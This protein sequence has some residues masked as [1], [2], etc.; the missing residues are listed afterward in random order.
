MW[1][2]VN[3]CLQITNFEILGGLCY[4]FFPDLDA[5]EIDELNEEIRK[6][7]ATIEKERKAA[8]EQFTKIE[9]YYLEKLKK[10]RGEVCIGVS[11]EKENR[12]LKEQLEKN[13]RAKI[14]YE[15]YQEKRVAGLKSEMKKLQEQLSTT[16]EYVVCCVAFRG[17]LFL[18]LFFC[19]NFIS[20][21]Y[22][23]DKM[24]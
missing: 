10:Q 21:I 23:L 1:V 14:S 11:L 22:L 19:P 6:L 24:F 8:Q 5:E 4:H 15:E 9:K 18:L 20:M 13:E 3:L 2:H 7:N 12:K 17:Y 16:V